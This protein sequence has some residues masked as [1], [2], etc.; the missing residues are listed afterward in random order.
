MA[1]IEGA[2]YYG[3]KNVEE[4]IKKLEKEFGYITITGCD[5]KRKI[6]TFK[7]FTKKNTV[8]LGIA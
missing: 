6:I 4:V 8:E 2:E 5:K 3:E 1:I 7:H